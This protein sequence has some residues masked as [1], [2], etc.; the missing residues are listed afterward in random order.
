MHLV[1]KKQTSPF[2]FIHYCSSST[3]HLSSS[4]SSLS[5][6]SGAQH[7]NGDRWWNSV[8]R[9]HL[10]A[11]MHMWITM[12]FVM[13]YRYVP[14]SFTQWVDVFYSL[15]EDW[16]LNHLDIEFWILSWILSSIIQIIFHCKKGPCLELSLWHH[17]LYPSLKLGFVICTDN[18]WGEGDFIRPTDH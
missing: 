10:S 3:L 13:F 1:L 4:S 14:S 9:D 12:T 8:V 17:G 18:W 2:S 16:Y 15:S 7:L 5:S 11:A 6:L